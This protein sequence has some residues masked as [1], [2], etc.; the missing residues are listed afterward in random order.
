MP[1]IWR[2]KADADSTAQEC[3]QD[4]TTKGKDYEEELAKWE[5]WLKQIGLTCPRETENLQTPSFVYT[6]DVTAQICTK[7]AQH[8][9]SNKD[10]WWQANREKKKSQLSEIST[11]QLML[12]S[13]LHYIHNALE[14]WWSDDEKGCCGEPNFTTWL[15]K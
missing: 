8:P 15:D 12:H 3:D 2:R 13:R 5:S 14:I 7:D 10:Q 9:R 4:N 6:V 1:D 11:Q